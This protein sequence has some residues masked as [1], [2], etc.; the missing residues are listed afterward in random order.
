MNNLKIEKLNSYDREHD[1][2]IMIAVSSRGATRLGRGLAA[3]SHLPI[4]HPDYGA[5]N[6]MAGFIRYL[7]GEKRDYVRTISGLEFDDA[8]DYQI[9]AHYED[10]L[11]EH[12]FRVL[13]TLRGADLGLP[14]YLHANLL[15]YRVYHDVEGDLVPVATP[16]WFQEALDFLAKRKELVGEYRT[17]MNNSHV[18]AHCSPYSILW[19]S[20]EEVGVRSLKVLQDEYLRLHEGESAEVDFWVSQPEYDRIP[21]SLRTAMGN[22]L[23]I[24][25][26]PEGRYKP[27]PPKKIM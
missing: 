11:Q 9:P 15:P 25:A 12:F 2:T 4:V 6:S 19:N 22:V 8:L 24:Q 16:V 7:G 3:G 23:K 17:S 27:A 1:G 13:T 18:G 26:T 10:V 20:P 5:F 21:E 14:R